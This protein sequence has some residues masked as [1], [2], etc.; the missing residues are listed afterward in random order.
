MK[1]VVGKLVIC[2]ENE[3]I[4][5]FMPKNWFVSKQATKVLLGRGGECHFDL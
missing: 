1:K 3:K 2:T 5:K 4:A